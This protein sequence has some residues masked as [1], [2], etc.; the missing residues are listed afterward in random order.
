MEL[1]ML[2]FCD[3]D[4]GELD[5]V[6]IHTDVSMKESYFNELFEIFNNV[7]DNE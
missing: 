2:P 3:S 7:L 4:D 5:T 1:K 6:D